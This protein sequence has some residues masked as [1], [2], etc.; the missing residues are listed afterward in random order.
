[1][2]GLWPGDRAAAPAAT[3]LHA[4]VHRVQG[5]GRGGQALMSLRLRQPLLWAALVLVL[6]FFTKRLVLANIEALRAK[7]SVIGDLVRFIYVRNS[8]SA[9]GLF[10]VGRVVLVG[11]SLATTAVL[12]FLFLRTSA[13]L[14]WRRTALALILGGALGNLIDRIFYD[15]MVVDFIDLGIGVH[16]FYTFNVADM[17]VT[18]GGVILFMCL[19]LDGRDSHE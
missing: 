14:V 13:E 3:A 5:E 6:D 4:A 15:G 2:P 19:L 11:V 9:M 18:I 7:V 1:M 16:R 10:P 8:G 17:G 12:V